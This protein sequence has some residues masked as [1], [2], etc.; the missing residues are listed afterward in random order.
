MTWNYPFAPAT[1]EPAK[2]SVSAL[3]RRG[4]ERDEEARPWFDAVTDRT[5]K[6]DWRYAKMWLRRE[7][8]G[9]P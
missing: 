2:T 4:A 3:R 7:L 8:S 5:V 6:S 1:I 9:A